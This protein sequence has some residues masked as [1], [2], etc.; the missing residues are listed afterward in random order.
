M[1]ILIR[2]INRSLRTPPESSIDKLIGNEAEE[3]ILTGQ[4]VEIQQP[5]SMSRQPRDRTRINSELL[6]KPQLLYNVT[7]S[8]IHSGVCEGVHKRWNIKIK[9]I[10]FVHL[11]IKISCQ[12]RTLHKYHGT[13][14]CLPSVK[15]DIWGSGGVAQ[16]FR[17]IWTTV[18]SCTTRPIYPEGRSLPVRTG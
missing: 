1:A 15:V 4:I 13:I 2:Q 3:Q 8:R 18:V 9:A 17:T 12:F 6:R 10:I 5:A 11:F 7:I 16:Q 14:Q